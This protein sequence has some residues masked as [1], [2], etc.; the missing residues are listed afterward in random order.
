MR[1]FEIR[2]PAARRD[3]EPL[4]ALL[5]SAPTGADIDRIAEICQDPDIQEWTTVPRGYTRADAE[6]FVTGMV[7]EGWE[8]GTS[9][10]WAVREERRDGTALVGM[11]GVTGR[12]DG[13]WEIGYWLAPET[14]GRGIVSR[15]PRALTTVAHPAEHQ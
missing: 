7:V 9:L 13:P 12:Q 1:P 4:P 10:N 6:G 2:V 8:S 5:L 11:M 3:D 15:P 14:R